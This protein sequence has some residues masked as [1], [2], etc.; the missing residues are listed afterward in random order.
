MIGACASMPGDLEGARKLHY[1][2]GYDAERG[3]VKDSVRTAVHAGVLVSHSVALFSETTGVAPKHIIIFADC[4]AHFRNKVVAQWLTSDAEFTT[5]SQVKVMWTAEHHGKTA[6]DGSFSDAKEWVRRKCNFRNATSLKDAIATA[7]CGSGSYSGFVLP[8]V[9]ERRP[10]G[11]EGVRHARIPHLRSTYSVERDGEHFNLN[12]MIR[13]LSF[14]SG[15]RV[16]ARSD[17][18]PLPDARPQSCS[19]RRSEAAG[20]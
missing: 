6:L 8:P 5:Q 7:Y 9:D 14:C 19:A 3:A 1:F 13:E 18:P 4:A 10:F 16:R 2:H 12:Y 20:P 11:H 15:R 17:C